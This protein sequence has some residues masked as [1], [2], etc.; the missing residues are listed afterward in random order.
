M[1]ERP[2]G[3]SQADLDAL[4][5]RLE[6]E[7]DL[8]SAWV[9]GSAARGALRP[10]S[11]VDLAVRWV[12]NRR[13]KGIPRAL[14]GALMEIAGRPIQLVDLD[15]APQALR[16]QVFRDGTCLFDRNPTATRCLHERTLRERFDWAPLARLIDEN[17]ERRFPTRPGGGGDRG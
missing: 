14:I 10:D 5:Q 1:Q 7:Q 15:D 17:L 13:P 11:D 16:F 8:E 9:F 3:T 2:V 6:A 4:R 12:P